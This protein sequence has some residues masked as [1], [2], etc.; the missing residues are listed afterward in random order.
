MATA[1]FVSVNVRLS[2]CDISSSQLCDLAL[3]LF[4][5]GHHGLVLLLCSLQMV[6]SHT[7]TSFCSTPIPCYLYLLLTPP[8]HSLETS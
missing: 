8:L 6:K 2:P 4:S 7:E 5:D 3:Q 1:S